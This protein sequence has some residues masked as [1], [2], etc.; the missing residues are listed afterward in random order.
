MKISYHCAKCKNF[1][2][3]ETQVIDNIPQDFIVNV[4]CENGH[5][6]KII[7]TNPLY[8]LLFDNSIIA[9]QQKNY[10][11]CIFEAASSLER[12]YEHA[13]RIF[14]IRHKDIDNQEKIERYNLAWKAIKHMSE[15]QLGAFI[16]L[17]LQLT[18]DFPIILNENLTKIRNST[19]HKGYLPS[20]EEAFKFLSNVHYIIQNNR[21]LIRPHDEDAYW[22][23]D[24]RID[25]ENFSNSSDLVE[26]IEYNGATFFNSSYGSEFKE[27][28]INYYNEILTL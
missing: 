10:R 17:F 19:I 4:R 16:M 14:I 8:S 28:M 2:T 27:S 7:L 3:K 23:F 9:F 24:Q 21:F 20:E 15:R 6:Q 18:D 26:T 5:D 22:L 1:L 25:F 12:F 13:I 11:A